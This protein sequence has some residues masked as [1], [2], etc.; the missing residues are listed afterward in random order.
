[1]FSVHN[2]F[3]NFHT[4]IM[5]IAHSLEISQLTIEFIFRS[6]DNEEKNG[7]I[8]VFMTLQH[9]IIFEQPVALIYIKYIKYTM[10]YTVT[11]AT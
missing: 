11:Y 9:F 7:V 3:S 6:T 2:L 4:K 10:R 1:M 5:I 8:Y